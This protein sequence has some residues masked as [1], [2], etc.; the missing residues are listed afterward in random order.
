MSILVINP[1][2]TSTKLAVYSNGESIAAR[3][4][5]HD[6]EILARYNRVADQL[7][8][9]LQKVREFLKEASIDAGSIRV[10]VGRGGLLHPLEGGVYEVSD[11]MLD[12]L[13]EARYGEHPCNLGAIM[14]RTLADEL[15]IPSY[16]VDPVVTDE[17]MDAAR[18][19]GLPEVERRSLFHALNQRGVARR[20]AERLGVAYDER[21]FIVCHMGGG[22]TIGAHRQGRVVDVVN[23][24][25]GEGPFT[26]E[27]TGALPI[28]PLLRGLRD[29]TFTLDSLEQAVLRQGGMYA[30]LSTND[31]REVV[32]RI[33]NGDKQAGKVFEA[34]AY[35][36][37]KHIGSMVPALVVDESGPA[38]AAVILTGGWPAANRWWLPSHGWSDGWDL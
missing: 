13:K 12:D 38:V 23:G 33:E 17:L 19:T 20:V 24:L 34:L 21:N 31:P 1:G 28:L 11:D 36:I 26:P 3:E 35:T 30:H 6:K 15:G 29:G 5:Q 7:E 9:R 4:L 8:P 2:S 37:A 22:I 16:V 10:V 18:L 32:A 14:A 27:R 25:D